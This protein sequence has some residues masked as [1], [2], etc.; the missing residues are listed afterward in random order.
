MKGAPE[1]VRDDPELV[2]LRNKLGLSDDAPAPDALAELRAAVEASPRDLD[3]KYAL[4]QALSASGHNA[5]AVDHLIDSVRANRA[6]ADEAA[7]MLLLQIFEQEGVD[8]DIAKSGRQRLASILY[9]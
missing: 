9:A 2:A 3:A 6:H 7:R 4:A 8:S 5:E 1:A